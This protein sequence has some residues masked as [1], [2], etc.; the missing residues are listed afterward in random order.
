[1]LILIVII[2]IT[3]YG[4]TKIEK[5]ITLDDSQCQQQ[6]LKAQLDSNKTLNDCQTDRQSLQS[7]LSGKT[8]EN[9]NISSHLT[10]CNTQKNDIQA[11]NNKLTSDFRS[12]MDQMSSQQEITNT[13]AS[14]ITS[15]QN[16]V[17]VCQKLLS[18]NN[19]QYNILQKKYNDLIKNY[20]AIQDKY[21]ELAEKYFIRCANYNVAARLSK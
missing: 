14:N 17:A 21:E 10:T 2:I 9:N 3:P 15:T 20:Q 13:N 1:M 5:F 16:N 12:L 4:Q 8:N 6:V 18:D 11:Q 19:N 7:L